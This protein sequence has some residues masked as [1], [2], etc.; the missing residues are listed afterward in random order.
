MSRITPLQLPAGLSSVHGLRVSAAAGTLV[1]HVYDRL[2]SALT[3][4]DAAVYSSS[5]DAESLRLNLLMDILC[6]LGL[7][8]RLLLPLLPLEEGLPRPRL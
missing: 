2:T 3:T 6:Q 8:L 4:P 5:L 1:D 7:L